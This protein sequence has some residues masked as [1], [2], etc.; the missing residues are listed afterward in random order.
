[1]GG[2]PNYCYY[3][4]ITHFCLCVYAQYLRHYMKSFTIPAKVGAHLQ[5]DLQLLPVVAHGLVVHAHGV[6]GVA[7][8]AK[9]PPLGSVVTQLLGEGQVSFVELEGS[10]VLALHLVDDA[11]KREDNI[12][13]VKHPN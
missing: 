7:H 11:C 12:P 2:K 10:L 9:G 1:M 5:R 4:V 8:V 3:T 6:V 13:D